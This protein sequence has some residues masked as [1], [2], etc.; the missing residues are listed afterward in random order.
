MIPLRNTFRKMER[1]VRDLA[2][3]SGKK[4]DFHISG[5]EVEL[6]KGMVELLGDPLIHMIRNA[7]DHG[8]ETPNERKKAGKSE[9][10][11]VYLKSYQFGGNVI[12]EITDDG[13]GLNLQ[14]IKEKAIKNGLLKKNE[15]ISDKD[16]QN[17]IFA[18]GFSTAEN[19]T[20]IS[21][22][23]VG[24][25]V[26]KKNITDLRGRIEI[27][28]EEGTGSSFFIKLPLTLAIIDG[29]IIKVADERYVIPVQ[30]ISEILSPDKKSFISVAKKGRMIKIRDKLHPVISLRDFFK[31]KK[32]ESEKDET[33][34][35]IVEYGEE[36]IGIIVDELL[37][38]QQIV[39]KSLGE[40]FNE[41]KGI[42][43]GS[44]MSDGCVSLI[45]D[46]PILVEE[47]CK[48]RS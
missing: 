22:R 40:I 19:I 36:K 10:S 13:R 5:E 6:D 32:S 41:Q 42:T 27:K 17:M 16:L 12:I 37:G 43:G 24:M 28:S 48:K 45:I 23:G 25:D 8:V 26:V 21:G 34:I 46:I 11:N 31:L 33:I 7:V 15:N 14:K 20:N 39:K 44:I 9:T 1:L 2:I 47:V 29:M 4:I 18:P 38:Q 30:S 3:S 35:V